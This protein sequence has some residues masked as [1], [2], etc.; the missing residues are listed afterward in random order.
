MRLA[1]TPS[2][3]GGKT[4]NSTVVVV[5]THETRKTRRILQPT[6]GSHTDCFRHR[7]P[8]QDD[9]PLADAPENRKKVILIGPRRFALRLA[10]T[11]EAHIHAHAATP[12]PAPSP[13]PTHRPC[14]PPRAAGY[15]P[16]VNPVLLGC[17]EAS[18]RAVPAQSRP[19]C[20]C[21]VCTSNFLHQQNKRW[22]KGLARFF[23]ETNAR[24]ISKH[25]QPQCNGAPLSFPCAAA[26]SSTVR[27]CFALFFVRNCVCVCST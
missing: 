13:Q 12:T 18:A 5:P 2:A 27:G 6:A 23:V 22:P 20:F 1:S 17:P 4:Y 21:F 11:P 8:Q 3:A 25:V 10:S 24:H 19:N 16:C 7:N 15:Q 9:V 14:L 26:L